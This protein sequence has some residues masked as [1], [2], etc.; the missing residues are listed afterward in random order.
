[1]HRF[2]VSFLS[3]LTLSDISRFS[4]QM[5]TLVTDD[6]TGRLETRERTT[7]DQVTGADNARTTGIYHNERTVHRRVEV[8]NVTMSTRSRN[9]GYISAADGTSCYQISNSVDTALTE[10]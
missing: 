1:M 10:T 7:R 8:S 6:L 4:R 5:V 9:R 2:Q 3:G